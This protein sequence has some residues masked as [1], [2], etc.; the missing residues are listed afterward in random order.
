[1]VKCFGC[2]MNLHHIIEEAKK[3]TG[4]SIV[5]KFMENTNSELK[6]YLDSE[7]LDICCRIIVITYIPNRYFHYL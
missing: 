6:K 4:I 3:I 1:M 5:N 7:E 2:G